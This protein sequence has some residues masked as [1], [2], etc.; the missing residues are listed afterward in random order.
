MAMYTATEKI[1]YLKTWA[2]SGQTLQDY[3]KNE[4]IGRTT[5]NLWAK[6]ILADDYTSTLRN[7]EQ[8]QILLKK[9]KKMESSSNTSE[10]GKSQTPA[11]VMVNKS[12]QKKYKTAPISIEYMGAKISIDENSVESVFRALKAVNG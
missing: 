8:K 9:L 5:M 10:N 11:L 4:G 1:S 3:C 12:I 6:N 7:P 2:A